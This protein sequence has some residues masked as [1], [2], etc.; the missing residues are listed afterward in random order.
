MKNTKKLLSTALCAAL[1]TAMLAGCGDSKNNGN[2][3]AAGGDNSQSG[4]LT[5]NYLSSRNT[6]SEAVMLALQDVADNYAKEN[7]DLDFSY[8]VE[9]ITDRASYLQKLKIL[10]SSNELPEWFESDPDTFFA[11][12]VEN[13]QVYNMGDLYDELGV[14]DKFFNIAKEYVKLPGSDEIYLIAWQANAEYFFYNKDLFAQA[15][16]TEVPKTMDELLDTCK[17]LKDAG[18]TPITTLG[19]D[20]PVLRYFAMIPFRQSGNDYLEKAC[21]GTESWGTELGI[22][23]AAYMQELA[24]YFQTGFS[25]GDT[26]TME[27]LFVGNK[28]AMLYDGTWVLPKLIDESTGDLRSDFSYFT[29]P[30]YKDNDTTGASDYFANCGIGMAIRKDAM[31]QE[32]KDYMKYVFDN[33]ADITL[34]DYK[35]LPSIQPSSTEGLPAVYQD[36]LEDV[37]NVNTFAK[38]WDVVIDSASLETL[39]KSS[40]ELLIGEMTPQEWADS[41]DKAVAANNK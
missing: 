26:D 3:S 41:L 1:C 2:N 20:W 30:T 8:E 27:D 23:N 21:A 14:S 40:T 13:D 28:A 18:I 5:I 38:C 19:S 32:M 39:H 11:S 12:L 16:I 33:Y 35:Q 17:A 15:G 36:I 4:S 10:A 29:M 6:T 31:T 9:S 24:Q 22:E 25:S 37:T 34:N 7:P